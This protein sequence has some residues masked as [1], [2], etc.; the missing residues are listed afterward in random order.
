[1]LGCVLGP[2]MHAGNEMSQW[3]LNLNGKVVPRQT[4]CPLKV[5]EVNSP[6]EI[7]KRQSYDECI[8]R[9]LGD[10]MAPPLVPPP[11][12][13]FDKYEDDDESPRIIPEQEDSIPFHDELV[14]AEVRLPQGD[15]MQSATVLGHFKDSD[16]TVKGRHS[17]DPM[18]Y[19]SL[20][21]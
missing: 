21:C 1:M 18:L 2:A 14:N 10:S 9:K 4:C 11:I 6:A 16:G 3:V 19:S 12:N 17:D 7:I 20:R 8:K 15:D 5:D 13:V